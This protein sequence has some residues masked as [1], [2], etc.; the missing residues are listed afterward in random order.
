MIDAPG[1]PFHDPAADA[2]LFEALEA[3]VAQTPHRQLIRLPQHLNDL[4]FA[5]ALVDQL[6]QDRALENGRLGSIMMRCR[7]VIERR[8]AWAMERKLAAILAADVVGYSRLMSADEAATFTRLRAH[9]QELFEPVI[10][11]HH[12]RVFKLM[13]D[14]LLAEFGS[15]ADAVECAA[16]LQ[17]AMGERNGGLPRDQRIDV[18]VGVHVG[19]VIVEDEDRHGDAVNV[20]ARLQQLAEPG[21]I[22]VSRPVVDH[23]RQRVAL[24]F[25]AA[26]R[27][28]TQ[29]HRRAG[30][31][32]S[33]PDRWQSWLCSE[34]EAGAPLRALAVGSRGHRRRRVGGRCR[35]VETLSVRAERNTHRVGGYLPEPALAVLPFTN[36]SGDPAL[37]YLGAGVAEDIITVLSAFPTLRVIS[38]TSSFTY[39]EPVKVQQVGQELGVSYVLEGSVRKTA[40]K[41]RFTV[42]LVDAA[43]GA[44]LWADRF[45]EEGEDPVA[46]QE[47]VG[48]RIYAALAGLTGAVRIYEQDSAWRKAAADL[49]E[50]DY[51]QRCKQLY[52]RFTPEDNAAARQIRQ[53]GLS[54]FPNSALLRIMLA[55]THLEPTLSRW[56]KPSDPRSRWRGSS[57][58]RPTRHK[59]SHAWRRGSAIG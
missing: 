14:G 47:K 7:P 54:H 35:R 5:Q 59:T 21:G 8:R 24:R 50:Y 11:G 37:D 6:P 57:A 10:A 44:H 38:R 12:G 36:M 49:N 17:R 15:A 4:A 16:A 23:I 53:E 27:G 20:A 45:D 1:Q 29:E 30:V 39:D 18:R 3:T 58:R 41:V 51:F 22:C 26:R 33:R 46:L 48:D 19:D 25:R 2:A 55:W 13:G 34:Q 32:L 40:D 31:G 52:F 9:R 56:T 42:Q 28:T 43:T